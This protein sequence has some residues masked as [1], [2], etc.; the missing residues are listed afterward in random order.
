[1]TYIDIFSNNGKYKNIGSLIRIGVKFIDSYFEN[2]KL[3]KQ[4]DLALY[5]KSIFYFLNR[6]IIVKTSQKL[7]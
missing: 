3:D 2:F 1:M 6:I 7:N 4:I 5:A